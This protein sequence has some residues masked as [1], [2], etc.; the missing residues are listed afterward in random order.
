MKLKINDNT[1]SDFHN[2]SAMIVFILKVGLSLKKI[3][4]NR[5]SDS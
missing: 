2:D 3:Q 1:S 4:I 5:Y